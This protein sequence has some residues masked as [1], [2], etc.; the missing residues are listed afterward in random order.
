MKALITSNT[1]YSRVANLIIGKSL[2]VTR[3]Q[4]K[5]VPVPDISDNDILVKVRAVALNA[6][7]FKHIDAISPTDCIVGYGYAGEVL[8]VGKGASQS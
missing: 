8:K 4:W 5:D 7:D 2:T 3:V 6:I 1:L